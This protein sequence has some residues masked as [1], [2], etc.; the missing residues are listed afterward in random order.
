[1]FPY[2]SRGRILLMQTYAFTLVSDCLPSQYCHF[3]ANIQSFLKTHKAPAYTS[4]TPF[5]VKYSGEQLPIN[6]NLDCIQAWPLYSQILYLHKAGLDTHTVHVCTCVSTVL[7]VCVCT[8]VSTV[9]YVCVCTCVSTVLY[10]CVCTCVST[11]LYVCVCAC[12]S[13]VL[14]VCVCTCVSTVLYVCVCACVST[15]LYVCVCACVC[16]RVHMSVT[17][18]MWK[19]VHVQLHIYY[20]VIQKR[21][22]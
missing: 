16:T 11:V 8:C 18:W 12:V 2:T 20:M 13:T 15:V 6:S 22:P 7:Y 5:G 9:L 14:Y 19:H 4:M 10:V 17:V 3:C 21:K 1:M